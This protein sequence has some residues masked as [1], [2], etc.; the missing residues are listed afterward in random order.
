[1][2]KIRVSFFEKQ[3]V[4]LILTEEWNAGWIQRSES[5]PVDLEVVGNK[6]GSLF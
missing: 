4:G 5:F 6:G 1:V 2:K 3:N